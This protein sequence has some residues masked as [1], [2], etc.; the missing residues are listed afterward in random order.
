VSR[1]G[2]P[3]LRAGCRLPVRQEADAGRADAGRADAGRAD[4]GGAVVEFIVIGVLLLVPLVYLVLTMAR[5]Q[6]GAFAVSTASR[7]AGRAF[8]TATQDA[9]G[10]G[11]AQVAA[12]MSFADYGFGDEAHLALSC[13]GSPCLRPEGRVRAIAT[14][15]VR[16]PLVPDF[17]AAAVPAS[18]PVSATHVATVDRFA[19]R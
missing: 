1:R 17:L 10:Y 12:A 7:E 16:M 13:D 19:G 8:T 5:L 14:V 2:W 18:I 4:A 3:G 15:E 9:D 6:G 11:R